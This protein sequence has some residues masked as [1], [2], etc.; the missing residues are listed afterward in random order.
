LDPSLPAKV[1]SAYCPEDG[2]AECGA[3]EEEGNGAEYFMEMYGSYAIPTSVM[4]VD[5]IFQVNIY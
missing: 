1:T 5:L 4:E 3:D 2:N